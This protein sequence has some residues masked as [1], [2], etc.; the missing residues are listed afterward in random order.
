MIPALILA[1]GRGTRLRSAIGDLPKPLADI[2]G[3]PFL[4]WMLRQLE[5]AGFRDAYLSVGYRHALV[6]ATMGER[7]GEVRLHY[8]VESDPLGTGGAIKFA[9]DRIDSDEVIAFNGDT[10]S[11]IDFR[12]FL[13]GARRGRTALAIALAQVADSSRYGTVDLNVE[14]RIVGFREKGQQGPG[15]INSGIYY[16]KKSVFRRFALPPEF[17]FE[18][19]FLMKH[20][21][22]L[23]IAGFPLVTDFIDIGVPEDYRRA[24]S[25]V[26][27]LV[28]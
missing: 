13:E 23:K 5:S 19:D 11:N 27:A 7:Q 14:G 17:S 8:V 24:Q 3:K 18:H 6:E 9:A 16:L 12:V 1:G 25:K 26:P 21:D 4:W 2:A 22:E 15:L 28:G 20:H 10:L